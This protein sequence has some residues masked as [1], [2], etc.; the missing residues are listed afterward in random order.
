LFILQSAESSQW[1]RRLHIVNIPRLGL[2]FNLCLLILIGMIL[3]RLA[4]L[5]SGA[6]TSD[7]RFAQWFVTPGWHVLRG[8]DRCD[9]VVA[10]PPLQ[11]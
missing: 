6:K 11:V 10:A 9:E 1:L 8:H 5:E 3:W 2:M 7:L 4:D